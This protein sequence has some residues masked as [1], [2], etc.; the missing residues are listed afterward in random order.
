MHP[1]PQTPGPSRVVILA[2][3][4][5][6]S[7][8]FG[9]PVRPHVRHLIRAAIEHAGHQCIEAEITSEADVGLSLDG[10]ER[11]LV[12]NLCYGLRQS[13]QP[14]AGQPDLAEWF[15]SAGG[16]L[17]GS[18]AESQ[19]R[20]QDKLEAG[21]LAETLGIAAPRAF[22]FDDALTQSGPLIVKP[23]EG[24]AHRG[25]RIVE[26]PARLADEPPAETDMVQEYLD[27]PEYTIGVIGNRSSGVR[28]L[29]LVRVRYRRDGADPAI[30]E[31]TTTSMAPDSPNRF[32][33]ADA[34]M[35]LFDALGLEDYARFDFRAV[36][37][38]GPVLMD[39][40]ALPNLAPRQLLATS[41]RWDGLTFPDLITELV[42]S[43]IVRQT[44]TVSG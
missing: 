32:G 42:N 27:G 13:G 25:V 24:A 37:G 12:F 14:D 23:R 4:P 20:C 19:R 28:T 36:R 29:P 11:P 34:A 21:V 22:A 3:V 5:V 44:E 17:I 31:W 38:R 41:A 43:A 30:Y 10:H 6:E 18:G 33:I 40:N 1:T 26:D 35:L 39:A 15:E 9:E 2:H 8:P 16:H 7:T